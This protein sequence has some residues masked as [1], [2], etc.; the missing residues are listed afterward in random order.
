MRGERKMRSYQTM[1][2]D[3][4]NKTHA[5]YKFHDWFAQTDPTHTYERKIVKVRK[6]Q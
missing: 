6:R 5:E 2:V 1:L 3:A 4:K